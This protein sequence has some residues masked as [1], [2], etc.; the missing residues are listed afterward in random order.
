[1]EIKIN[2]LTPVWTGDINS[3][4]K[5]LKSTGIIGSLRWWTEAILKGIGYS[6][7]DPTAEI[8]CPQETNNQKTYCPACLIFGATGIRRLFRL[9]VNGGEKVFDGGAIII[10]PKGRNRG[11]YL[12]S[13]LRGQIDLRIIS[14]DKDFNETLLLL[15]LSIAS[16]WGE[17]G[18]KTQHGY[19]VVALE[20]EKEL[21]F[22]D[23]KNSV[24][25]ILQE[26]RL[27]KIGI[28]ERKSINDVLPNLKE[29]FFAKVQ[30][31]AQDNN[32]WKEVDGIK[33]RERKGDNNYYK[34]YINDSRM[35]SWINSD[36][37][38]I[39]PA[40]KNWLRFGNGKALWQSKNDNKYKDIET[41]LFGTTRGEKSASKI[42]ISCAYYLNN[43]LWEFRIS[44]WIP[45][46]NLPN[47]FDRNNFLKALMASLNGSGSINIPWSNLLGNKTKDHKLKVWREFNSSRD[48]V[49]PNQEDMEKYL[50][51]L[52]KGEERNK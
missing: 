9:E 46:N 3:R 30:F 44:G 23:F 39:A 31:E 5:S 29:M 24:R 7:C 4:G 27:R 16:N 19:G 20:E 2:I 13:G 22:E 49:S 36:S 26:A 14:L 35:I 43:K 34:G 40:I 51:S 8:R 15:P 41:S 37:I 38:P 28:K 12:G 47:G 21:V 1:M 48:T 45:E 17:I 42:N 33:E 18:A 25:R 6:V 10:K 32:W 52:I 11:W 50:D